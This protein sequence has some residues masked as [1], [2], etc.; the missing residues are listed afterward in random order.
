M[1]LFSKL[2][3]VYNYHASILAHYDAETTCTIYSGIP[4][5]LFPRPKIAPRVWSPT[6]NE[7]FPTYSK[8]DDWEKYNARS[9]HTANDWACSYMSLAAGK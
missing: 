2:G 7:W 9:S 3:T 6:G 1:A 5:G 8:Q 4:M